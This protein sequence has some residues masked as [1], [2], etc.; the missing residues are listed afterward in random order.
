M[1]RFQSVLP[2][3]PEPKPELSPS[4]PNHGKLIYIIGM[5]AKQTECIVINLHY[6]PPELK[7]YFVQTKGG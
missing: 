1:V 3:G 5:W 6:P 4:R 2:L 7:G